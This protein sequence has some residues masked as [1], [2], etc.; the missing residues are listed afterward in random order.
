MAEL[1]HDKTERSRWFYKPL[2]FALQTTITPGR[3]GG[4]ALPIMDYT[5][6][7][8]PKGVPFSD[9]CRPLAN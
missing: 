4:G 1:V 7:L 8:R 6:R 5:V 2:N 3:G 9:Y